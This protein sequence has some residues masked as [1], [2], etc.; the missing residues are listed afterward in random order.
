MALALSCALLGVSLW[1]VLSGGRSSTVAAGSPRSSSRERPAMLPSAALAPVSAAIG[2]A[3]AAYRIS[4]SAGGWRAR[5]PAQ[6]LGERFGTEGARDPAPGVQLDAPGV[7]LG[8]SVRAAGYGPSLRALGAAAPRVSANRVLYRRGGLDEWYVNGP[9]GVEQGFTLPQAPAGRHAGPLTIAMKLS[10]DTRPHLE[11]GRR[12]IVLRGAGGASLRYGALLATG[13]HGRRLRSWLELD[14]RT[15]LLRVDTSGARYPLRIDPLIQQ[16]ALH[17]GIESEGERFGYNVALSADGDTALVGTRAAAGGVWVFTRSGSEWTQQGQPLKIEEEE[18]GK[19]ECEETG[20]CGFERSVALSAD[21]NTALIGGPYDHDGRGAAWVF[22]RSG[23]TWSQQG[24][25][26]TG[27]EQ[28]QGNARFGR[29]VA[30]SGEGD[31]A[32]VGA[33]KNDEGRGAVWVFTRSGSTWAQPGYMLTG[34]EQEMPEGHFGHGVALSA[35]GETALVGAPGDTEYRGAAWV[36]TRSGATWPQ[37]GAILTGGEEEIGA[38]RFGSSVALSAFGNTA[39]IGART[40]HEGLGAAWVLTRSGSTWTP[41]GPKLGGEGEAGEGQ[42]GAKVALSAD[43]EVAL[44]SAPDDARA[45]AAWLFTRP[46]AAWSQQG[47]KIAGVE[48]DGFGASVAL[49]S[50]GT[51]ALIGGPSADASAGAAWVFQNTSVPPP[52][53]ASISA[54]SGPSEGGTR[55]TITGSGFLTGATV[56]IGGEASSVEVLS[57]TELTAVTPAHAAGSEEVVVDDADGISTGGP[58]YTYEEPTITPLTAVSSGTPSGGGNSPAGG[59]VLSNVVIALPAPQLGLT[60]NLAPVSGEVLV[61]LPGSSSFTLLTGLRQVPFGTIINATH[62]K[63]RVTTVGPN[64]RLQVMTYYGGEF[65]LTQGRSGLVV[66]R[67]L[68]GNFSVCPTARERSH[69]AR[70]S[71]TRASGKH[72]VRKLWSEGHGKYSTKGNYAS[73]A[74]LGTRWLTEDLCDGTLIHVVTD[75]VRVTNLVNHRHV[76]VTAGHSYFAKAP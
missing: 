72:V 62:G 23:S 21:G 73:G 54:E 18:D 22:T 68:G 45:G 40:D 76:T 64:G 4:A 39:L 58:D 14:G 49:S 12:S 67:L 53:V 47:A 41:Q 59:G 30:L 70:A 34:G 44:I 42:F 65:E 74:V 52:T 37:Q 55:V 51:T 5:D 29:S 57:E 20:E 33:S 66:A 35:D 8:L 46:G 60:G 10:G 38:G 24:V 69:L 6:R 7:Q 15:I 27:G 43:G 56:E 48:G 13:A 26:L 36:F 9:L 17:G 1:G 25:E 19:E 2:A 32:L 75:R 63:V 50:D 3:G 28:E 16:A 11:A 31:T 61:K 71:S